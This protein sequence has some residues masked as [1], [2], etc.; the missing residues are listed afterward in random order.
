MISDTA[1]TTKLQATILLGKE[2]ALFYFC[3]ILNRSSGF[4]GFYVCCFSSKPWLVMSAL[5]EVGDKCT[6]QCQRT[7]FVTGQNE[8]ERSSR[9]ERII[10]R[11]VDVSS[12]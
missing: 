11:Y 6:P 12:S 5:L 9:I 3:M 10:F 2:F 4:I 7:N 8:A 1:G